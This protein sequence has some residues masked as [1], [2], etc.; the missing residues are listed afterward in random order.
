[1]VKWKDTPASLETGQEV[2]PADKG[3]EL[4]VS[5]AAGSISGRWRTECLTG[6]GGNAKKMLNRGNEAKDLLKLKELA[7]FMCAKRTAF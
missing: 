7:L 4:E 1:M 2:R 5:P 3:W 6:G